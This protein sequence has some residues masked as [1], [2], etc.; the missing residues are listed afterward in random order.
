MVNSAARWMVTPPIWIAGPVTTSICGN[1]MA[2]LA[3]G[4]PGMSP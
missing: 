1:G 4:K 2:R 3:S